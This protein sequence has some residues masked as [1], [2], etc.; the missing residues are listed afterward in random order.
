MY[1]CIER[2]DILQFFF[3]ASKSASTRRF[4]DDFKFGVGSSSYQ[5]EGGWKQH[6]KG[7]SI[8]DDLTHRYPHKIADSSNGD[9]TTDS[10][11][12]VCIEIVNF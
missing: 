7:E 11:T 8:W 1:I 3:S 9:M 6:G 12:H 4:P 10:Y 5:I 2:I